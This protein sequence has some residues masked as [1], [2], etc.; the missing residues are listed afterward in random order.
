MSNGCQK[1]RVQRKHLGEAGDLVFIHKSPPSA[2]LT[3][4][5]KTIQ[6]HI[7]NTKIVSKKLKRWFKKLQSSGKWMSIATRSK[8]HTGEAG[9]LVLFHKNPPSARL[10]TK[11]T[12]RPTQTHP[13][14]NKQWGQ[15]CYKPNGLIELGIGI[16]NW[17]LEMS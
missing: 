4:T 13:N 3:T 6:D 16:P 17:K 11:H 5:E 10:T 1:P 2:P 9:N 12:N 7:Q 15:T 14:V 8:K